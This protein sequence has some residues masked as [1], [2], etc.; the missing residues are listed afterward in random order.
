[1]DYGWWSLVPPVVAIV[2]AIATRR[3][4]V[5][6][7]FGSIVGVCILHDWQA[8]GNPLWLWPVYVNSISGQACAIPATS[9]FLFS[10]RS[11]GP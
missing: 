10:R 3:V 1:M 6:L 8:N 2:L 11:W 9:A 4:V 5:S 7:L